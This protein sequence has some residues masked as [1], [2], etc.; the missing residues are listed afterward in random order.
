MI[1]AT[2]YV[3]PCSARKAPALKRG[4]LPARDAYH[5]TAFRLCRSRLEAARRP[6]CIL[7]GWHGFLWP[8]TP[9][10]DYDALMPWLGPETVWD[11]ALG[12]IN[13]RQYAR[14]RHAG[15]IVVLGSR[16]Y[17][18]AARWLLEREVEGPV[19]GLPIGRMLHALKHLPL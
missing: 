7:S 10:T 4:P 18:H 19:A 3:V 11:D 14:L 15:R 1:P 16:R 6:W 17:V 13:D 12:A 8:S 9:I 5:G 2:L